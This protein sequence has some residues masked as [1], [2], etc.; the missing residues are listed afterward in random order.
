MTRIMLA[1]GA[2]LAIA[3]C[4]P[5]PDGARS[6]A[7]S[8]TTTS[9]QTGTMGTGTGPTGAATSGT[10]TTGSSAGGTGTTSPTG[11]AGTMAGTTRR[12]SA[13]R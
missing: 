5:R 9:S 13:R 3:A 12:D 6:A 8:A 10:G 7:D 11:A 2:A 1:T 4:G